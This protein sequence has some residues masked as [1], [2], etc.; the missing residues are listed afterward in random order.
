[1]ET[2]LRP[3]NFFH[4]LKL[5]RRA[6]ATATIETAAIVSAYRRPSGCRPVR[7][8]ASRRGNLTWRGRSAPRT[9]SHRPGSSKRPSPAC[10]ALPNLWGRAP[11]SRARPTVRKQRRS[12]PEHAQNQPCPS[13]RP[14]SRAMASP[15]ISKN[16]RTRAVLFRSEWV[17]IHSSPA[18][19]DTG[20]NSARARSASRSPR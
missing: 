13:N 3:E 16:A 15:T 20:S 19:S 6:S 1:M 4:G 18:S 10:A 8:S 14:R 12:C 17:T 5:F 11:L 9:R 7:Y 2:R